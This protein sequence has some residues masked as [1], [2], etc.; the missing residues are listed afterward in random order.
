VLRIPN[1][2]LHVRFDFHSCI[3]FPWKFVVDC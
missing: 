1:T 3:S 2:S